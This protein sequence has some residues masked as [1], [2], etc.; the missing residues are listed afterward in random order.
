MRKGRYKSNII[1][2]SILGL[3]IL[4]FYAL[5]NLF[6]LNSERPKTIVLEKGLF[7]EG[8]K[9][10]LNIPRV[11][12][13]DL[14]D[15]GDV[16]WTYSFIDNSR[17]FYSTI[18]TSN[19]EY[20]RVSKIVNFNNGDTIAEFD[21][22]NALD[23]V[24][25]NSGELLM[26]SI[27]VSG[28][29]FVRTY[30]LDI[31]ENK[32][33]NDFEGGGM[34]FMPNEE[35]VIF[36]REENLYL[37]DLKTSQDKFLFKLDEIPLNDDIKFKIT[38]D[39]GMYR[40]ISLQFSADGHLIYFLT[41]YKAGNAIYRLNLEEQNKLEALVTGNIYAFNLLNNR[42]LLMMGKI[43][44]ENG[45][46]IYSTEGKRDKAIIKG[47]VIK[48]DITADG[49]LAYVLRD[50]KGVYEL[51]I[52][53]YDGDKVKADEVIY[54]DTRYVAFLGWSKTDNTL[55]YTIDSLKGTEILRF[56]FSR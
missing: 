56:R 52:A 35:G 34:G 37:R 48:Y 3:F 53:Y 19:G 21:Y 28:T 15:I 10:E 9:N 54:I 6:I 40:A 31:Q 18:K 7:D 8:I 42:S 12:G 14:Y 27:P 38:K 17:M 26:Y 51:H 45:I 41:P 25:S 33:I 2:I 29:S 39:Y 20:N 36:M 30:I 22:K 1:L 11:E 5:S 46:F 49:R 4:A 24:L 23:H 47:E 50:D 55:F 16:A 32:I 44:D 13:I 43:D